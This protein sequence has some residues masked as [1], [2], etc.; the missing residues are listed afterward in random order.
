LGECLR[1]RRIDG[2]GQDLLVFR[3]GV[4]RGRK[5]ASGELAINWN[6]FVFG[7]SLNILSVMMRRLAARVSVPSCRSEEEAR[8]RVSPLSRLAVA[9]ALAGSLA[10]PVAVR[11]QDQGIPV[12]TLRAA[13]R[14]PPDQLPTV[15]RSPNPYQHEPYNIHRTDGLS[16]NPDDCMRWGCIDHR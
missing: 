9:A 16:R 11:A 5:E 12:M 8:M 15:F 3:N 14:L 4:G 7:P 2:C 10:A 6:L 1:A 13:L